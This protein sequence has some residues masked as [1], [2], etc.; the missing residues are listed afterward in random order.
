MKCV[1]T[2]NNTSPTI[3]PLLKA[4]INSLK[5]N[6]SLEPVV[7][8]SN[9]HIAD[10]NNMIDQFRDTTKLVD[11]N[12][13]ANKMLY[14]LKEKNVP[15]IEHTL[16]FKDR[17]EHFNFKDAKYTNILL[18]YMYLHYPE[19]YNK[20]FIYTE[21]LRMD[22]PMIFPTEKFVMYSDCDV[23]FLKDIENWEFR[24]PIAAVKRDGF[25]NN[26]IMIFNIPYMLECYAT[27]VN[28]YCNSNYGFDVGNVT[29]QGAYNTFFKDSTHK[30]PLDMNWH[31]FWDMNKEAKIAHFAG[32]KPIDYFNMWNRLNDYDMMFYT[33][34]YSKN[35]VKYWIERYNEYA[36]QN[37][38]IKI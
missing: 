36:E 6:T 26:G 35:N 27:F 23:I 9:D 33:C 22:I 20:N 19:Y 28:F 12:G 31:V 2:T 30:L 13:E 18:K 3:Y 29:S 25:F 1:F 15:V 11:H 7:V 37:D 4:A 16:L 21:S 34:G 14:W 17:I 38:R 8:W 5:A 24:K 32:P 10:V